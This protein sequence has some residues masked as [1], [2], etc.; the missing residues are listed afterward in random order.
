MRSFESWKDYQRAVKLHK[1]RRTRAAA[2]VAE[3]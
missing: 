1:A 3:I 2:T